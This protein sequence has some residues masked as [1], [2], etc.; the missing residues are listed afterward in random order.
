MNI[1]IKHSIISRSKIIARSDDFKS[2]IS[3]LHSNFV[4]DIREIKNKYEKPKLEKIEACKKEI[5][6]NRKRVTGMIK[7]IY[8]SEIEGIKNIMFL[9]NDKVDP[10][11]NT[12]NVDRNSEEE[13]E[14]DIDVDDV[15]TV[16]IIF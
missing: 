13:E 10:K 16:D 9:F 11:N 15:S 4:K 12:S 5:A 7:E 14:D 8:E 2:D 3:N 6:W 1:S